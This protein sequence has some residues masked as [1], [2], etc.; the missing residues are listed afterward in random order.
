MSSM[1]STSL[2]PGVVNLDLIPVD[3]PLT[4]LGDKKNPYVTGWQN[5][6]K[7]I[8]E[9]RKEIEKGDCKAV[10]VLSGPVYNKPYGLVWIDVDGPSVYKLIE[11]V[12]KLTIEQALPKTLTICSG[13][14]GRE[15]KL[16]KVSKDEWKH[17]IRNK[18]A[19]HAEG[20]GEKLEVLW[21]RH[22]GVLMGAHPDT[23]GYYTKEGEDFSFVEN[24]TPIPNWILGAMMDK[25]Q[26]LGRPSEDVTRIY[27]QNF[28][29]NSKFGLER[30]MKEA[31]D[32]M[33]AL[34]VEAVDDYDIWITIGQSLHSVDDTLLDQ[35]DEWSK[36]SSKY[37]NGECRRRWDSFSQAGGRGIGSLFH[38]AKDYG[39]QP[40]QSHRVMGVDDQTLE[41]VTNILKEM[42]FDFE[43]A[44]PV[45][46]QKKQ[47]RSRATS[48]K[49]EE[50]S[51]GLTRKRNAPSDEILDV[52][53]SIYGGTLLFSDVMNRFL[54]Y[55]H[56][57]STKG[58]WCSM[59]ERE[60]KN[61]IYSKLKAVRST[62]LPNGFS[63][64]LVDDMYK[65]LSNNLIHYDWNPNPRL[66]LFTNGVLDMGSMELMPPQK[67]FYLTRAV[68]YPYDKYATCQPI[69]DWLY[70]TQNGDGQRV[71]LL[72]AWLRAVLT[73]S[74]EI[75]KFAEIV[76]PGKSGKSSFAN[77]CHALVGFE[78][79][80]VS[81]LEHLEKNRFETS[82]LVGKKL[83]LFND[84]ERYGG[85]VSILK[86]LTGRDLIRNEHKYKKDES[87]FKFDGLIIMTANEQIA[88]TDPS[89]G[90]FRRRLT[91]PFDRPFTGS[92]KEQCVL[93]DV[94][95]QGEAVGKFAPYLQGLVNWLLQMSDEEMREYLMETAK[96]VDYFQKYN[97]RQRIRANPIMDWLHHNVVF[98]MNAMTYIGDCK[99]APAGSGDYYAN[100]NTRLYPNYC[101]FSRRSNNGTLSRSRFESMLMDIFNHQLNL[102][103][104]RDNNRTARLFN[105]RLRS[106]QVDDHFPSL[107]DLSQDVSKYK[108]FYGPI[109]IQYNEQIN[110][111]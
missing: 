39:W 95:N 21:K 23:P 106:A 8:N 11:D 97:T 63:L 48:K 26:K 5:N 105:V 30:T 76:G 81:T 29:I 49:D 89:S 53:V 10:G 18:Y 46:T 44:M 47:K 60:M 93:I 111:D 24:L 96:K 7:D 90:L 41:E 75:Q 74:Q 42:D 40:D 9:I 2:S 94:N 58:L 104:Y 98:D 34:P 38:L 99:P 57:R 88:T 59:T 6:P 3:W 12:S 70:Y 110:E 82:N 27:G 65:G 55:Q 54:L 35:W 61:D 52:L 73:S 69:I 84:V 80:S 62:L 51:E 87:Y 4:P 71:E 68:P 50:N 37:Q 56:G 33:W 36:Q 17:F 20:D 78:N 100:I 101:E 66:L 1:S 86:A 108:E 64:S 91:I 103:V 72:R 16:Y 43:L 13:R 77:L 22:Q 102:N 31:V 107:V 85:N 92:S 109:R 83:V 28:A 45:P 79:A 15:R 19:W 67:E 14:E 32:A 25:N